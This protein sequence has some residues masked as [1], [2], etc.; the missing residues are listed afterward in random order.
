MA[1]DT[2]ERHPPLS[3]KDAA[4]LR[5]Q[6]YIDGRWSDADSGQTFDIVNPATA[7]KIGTAPLMGA[8]E[9]ARAIA[10]ADKACRRGAPRRPRSA[11]R[12]FANGPSS[13]SRTP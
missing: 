5:S 6:C 13:S 8:G 7:V 10:A 1:P 11:P 9:T 4:L 12:S 3:L 2:S